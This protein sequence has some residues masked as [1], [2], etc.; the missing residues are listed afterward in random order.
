MFSSATTSGPW[1][2]CDPIAARL[3]MKDGKISS[4]LT[5]LPLIGGSDYRRMI[6]TVGEVKLKITSGDPHPEAH[7][8]AALDMDSPE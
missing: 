6:S 5:I 7:W 4:D 3:S 8:V 2:Q 1:S